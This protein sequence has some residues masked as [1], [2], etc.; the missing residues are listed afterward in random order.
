[1]VS[2]DNVA[3]YSGGKD[4]LAMLLLAY[5]RG[6]VFDEII[7]VDVGPWM[8]G[9]VKEQN[10]MVEEV[11]GQEITVIDVSR[12]ILEGFK[13]WGFPSHS[14]RWCTGIKKDNMAKYLRENYDYNALVQWMGVTID[15]VKRAGKKKKGNFKYPL[16]EWGLSSRDCLE[17]CYER[18]FFFE[19]MYDYRVHLNCWCCPLQRV[20][21][22]RHIYFH[23][24]KLWGELVKMQDE[25]EG[26]FANGMT[27]HDYA[28]RFQADDPRYHRTLDEFI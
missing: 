6:V 22:L 18:G 17:V 12:E 26:Y 19:G 9:F 15:E 27:V 7:Y 4:S 8:W 3:L 5:E 28:K 1:L 16:V 23:Y 25:A 21:E 24:P 10:K 20:S 14:I 11:I 13:K 2:L